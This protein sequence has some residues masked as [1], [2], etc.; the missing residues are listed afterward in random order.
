[1]NRV[2]TAMVSGG[3]RPVVALLALLATATLVL[4]AAPA[5][6]AHDSLVSSSPSDGQTVP[7]VPDHIV[8]TMNEAPVSVGTRV[9][10]QGPDGEVQQGSPKLVKNSVEQALVAGSPAGR[11]T[12]VWRV[13]SRDGHPVSGTFSFTASAAGTATS[14][15]VTPTSSGSESMTT[16]PSPGTTSATTAGQGASPVSG[17][18]SGASTGGSGQTGTSWALW[19]AI[20]ILAVAG[21]GATTVRRRRGQAERASG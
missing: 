9:V 19:L 11:Y 4:V 2:A 13:T 10:V 6:S 8:L 17:P 20:A 3:R 16:T 7:A 14:G 18:T 21:V 15:S 12:V 5:A 1:M